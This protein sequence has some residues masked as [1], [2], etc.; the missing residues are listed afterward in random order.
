MFVLD[1]SVALNYLLGQDSDQMAETIILRLRQE[2][3]IAPAHWPL[4][5]GNAIAREVRRDLID[6]A[7]ALTLAREAEAWAVEYDG[8]M[9]ARALGD[10]LALALTHRLTTY[11]AAYLELC[12]RQRAPLATFDR[13]LAAAARLEAVSLLLE[14]EPPSPG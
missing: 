5:I 13:K 10:S 2:L 7:S 8:E 4:E 1:A 6:S 14:L 9:P 12:L 3:A 11:D